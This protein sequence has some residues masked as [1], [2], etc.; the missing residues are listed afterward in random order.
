MV[1]SKASVALGNTTTRA[2]A[3]SNELHESVKLGAGRYG[4]VQDD[5]EERREWFVRLPM[6]VSEGDVDRERDG[7]VETEEFVDEVDA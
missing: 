7:Q 2:S 6:W 3:S 1:V 5:V 4:G